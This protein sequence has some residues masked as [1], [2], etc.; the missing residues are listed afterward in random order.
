[1]G[2]RYLTDLAA[3]VAAAGL[4]VVEVDGWESRARGSGGYDAGRPTHVIVHHTASPASSDGWPDV[5]YCTFHDDDAPLCN[6]YL[7]RDGTVYVCAAG[8]TNTNGAGTDPCGITPADAMNSHAVGIEAGNDGTGEPWRGLQVDAYLDLV[9]ALCDAYGIDPAQ[10][11]AHHEWA[12]SRKT[13]PAGPSPY[14]GAGPWDMD[15]FRADLTGDEPVT[16]QDVQRIAD[17]VWAKMLPLAQGKAP[18][19]AQVIVGDTL[20][21]LQNMGAQVTNIERAVGA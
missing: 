7:S 21:G 10:C 4:E 18:A 19:P 15:A 8:A 2:A 11:H 9:S 3:V 20:V 5:E 13:D 14:A 16:D 12:P 6:L 1:M 17:A